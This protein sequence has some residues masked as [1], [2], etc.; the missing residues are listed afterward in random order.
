MCVFITSNKLNTGFI[1]G[2]VTAVS[3]THISMFICDIDGIKLK[4]TYPKRKHI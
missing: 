4:N 2:F 1:Y 3:E